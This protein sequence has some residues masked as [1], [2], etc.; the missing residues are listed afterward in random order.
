MSKPICPHWREVEGAA[1]E[2]ERCKS[3]DKPCSCSGDQGECDFPAE[4]YC[5]DKEER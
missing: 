2:E 3:A 1:G 5:E 4:L